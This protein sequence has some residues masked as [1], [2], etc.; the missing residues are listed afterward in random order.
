MRGSRERCWVVVMGL[1]LGLCAQSAIAMAPGCAAWPAARAAIAAVLRRGGFTATAPPSLPC[2]LAARIA[3]ADELEVAKSWPD[4]LRGTVEARL[5][6]VPPANCLPFVVAVEPSAP[7]SH[8]RKA[9]TA[10]RPGRNQA[11][12]SP[13]PP[14]VRS[15][16]LV[17]PGQSV[18]LLWRLGTLRLVRTMVCLDSGRAGDRVRARARWRAGGQGKGP[19]GGMAGGRRMKDAAARLGGR[20]AWLVVVLLGAALAPARDRNKPGKSLA[21]YLRQLPPQSEQSDAPSGPGSLWRDQGA[22]AGLARD[23]KAHRVG[24]PVTILVVESL[25]SSNTGNVASDRSFHASS[26]INALAGRVKTG[27]VENL[28]SPTSSQSLAGKAQSTTSSS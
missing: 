21:E 15:A 1:A 5:R 18:S 6:C 17:K 8:A 4:P 20:A 13:G 11:T 24:D 27:G 9:G 16:P 23:Y 26:G 7:G 14:S 2:E 3:A 28:F 22:L 25:Q 19:F 12:A 10:A